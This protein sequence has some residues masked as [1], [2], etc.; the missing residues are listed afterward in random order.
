MNLTCLLLPCFAACLL[1]G[2]RALRPCGRLRW[3]A[4]WDRPS[5]QTSQARLLEKRSWSGCGWLFFIHCSACSASCMVAPSPLARLLLHE[6]ALLLRPIYEATNGAMSPMAS[7]P[8][9]FPPFLCCPSSSSRERRKKKAR[10][11]RQ[12][13]RSS[14]PPPVSNTVMQAS[15]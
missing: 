8:P 11:R 4:V 14:S 3:F 1:P 5:G 12:Q 2:H 13:Q 6:L 15:M 7:R 9:L 10:W